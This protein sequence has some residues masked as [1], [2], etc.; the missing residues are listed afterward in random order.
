M[1]LG[2]SLFATQAVS[3]HL[4]RILTA[5]GDCVYLAVG[6]KRAAL[7]DTGYGLGDLRSVVEDLAGGLPVCVVLTHGHVDHVGGASQ[8]E[9]VR[10]SAIDTPVAREHAAIDFRLDFL[11]KT[12]PQA[13]AAAQLSREDFLEPKPLPYGLI[14]DG[15]VLDLGGVEIV[16]HAVPGHTP[17]MLVPVVREDRV[18]IFGDACGENT[19]LCFPESLP[20]RCYHKS[21]VGLKQHEDEWD[22][23]V[24]NHGTHWSPKSLLDRNIMLS[25]R[26]MAGTD[27]KVPLITPDGPALVASAEHG[28]G[29][30]GNI[31]YKV[32][33]PRGQ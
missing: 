17:G 15:D 20:V 16:I 31:V 6:S 29:I 19:L 18:A 30:H 10:M 2:T 8:F 27:D 5:F 28:S 24:R 14:A 26:I 11:S 25:E 21:L 7:F 22:T 9:D 12:L 23:V 1:K 3:D 4:T 33:D 13:L 32:D